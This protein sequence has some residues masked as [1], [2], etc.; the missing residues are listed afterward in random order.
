MCEHIFSSRGLYSNEALNGTAIN[1]IH[2][3]RAA[4]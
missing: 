1:K 4:Q 2:K 3:N